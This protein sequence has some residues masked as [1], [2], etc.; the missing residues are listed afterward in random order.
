MAIIFGKGIDNN[1]AY[2]DLL[3]NF[4]YITKSGAWYTIE[5][6]NVKERVQGMGK[7]ISWIGSHRDLVKEEINKRGG[8]KLLLN[9][10]RKVNLGS[11]EYNSEI[12]S[13]ENVDIQ[14]TED[15]EDNDATIQEF[16]S[17]GETMGES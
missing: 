14:G 3:T 16:E 2:C 10:D 9:E 4:G 15:T 5:F 6:D 8:Y 11:E 1:Y 17:I 13:D 7:V 12:E